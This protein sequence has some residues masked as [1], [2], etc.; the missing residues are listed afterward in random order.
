M[1]LIEN[2]WNFFALSFD[3]ESNNNYMFVNDAVGTKDDTNVTETFQLDSFKW[4]SNIFN[5]DSVFLGGK[6]G[7]TLPAFDGLISCFQIFDYG[8]TPAMIEYKKFCPDLPVK[9]SPC[10][11]GYEF[12]DGYCYMVKQNELP[13]TQADAACIPPKDS[14][15]ESRLAWTSKLEHFDFISYL[16]KEQLGAT[17]VWVG[18]SD[19]DA[20]TFFVNSLATNITATSE[21]FHA[22]IDP[23]LQPCVHVN[24]GDGGYLRTDKCKLEKAVVCMSRPIFTQPDFPC[25]YDFFPYRDKCLSPDQRQSTYDDAMVKLT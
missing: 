25:P 18:A 8:M 1:E 9:K 5:G 23:S 24:F 17:S 10:T 15:W 20:D 14:L 13:Y 21:L 4:I 2:E 19:R 16:A 7:S 6:E 11:P 12:F 22:D 3:E